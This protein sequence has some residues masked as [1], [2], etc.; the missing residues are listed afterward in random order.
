MN[1]GTSVH[2]VGSHQQVKSPRQAAWS[3]LSRAYPLIANNCGATF[4]LKADRLENTTT[5]WGQDH[6]LSTHGRSDSCT[7]F[8]LYCK[9]ISPF[10]R[11]HRLI[12]TSQLPL[13]P[14]I[15]FTVVEPISL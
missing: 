2:E 11:V 14:R 3:D 7:V 6:L 12:M 5:L 10:I 15:L 8:S 13:V 1:E 4:W 9:S